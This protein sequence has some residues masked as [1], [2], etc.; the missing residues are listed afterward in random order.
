MI[1]V[2]MIRLMLKRLAQAGWPFQTPSQE[3]LLP[4]VPVPLDHSVLLN[5]GW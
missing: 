4:A 2:A 3:N 1:Y 5:F